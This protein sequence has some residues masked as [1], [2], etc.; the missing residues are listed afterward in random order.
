[1][2]D[3]RHYYNYVMCYLVVLHDRIRDELG[4][5]NSASSKIQIATRQ[6]NYIDSYKFYDIKWTLVSD[7]KMDT[8]KIT[9]DYEE[10]E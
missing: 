6:T 4:D 1:M 9:L 7:Y 3:K 10:E 5:A 8:I 2:K